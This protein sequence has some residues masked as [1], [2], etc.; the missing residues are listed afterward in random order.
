MKIVLL[1]VPASSR[2]DNS[3]RSCAFCACLFSTFDLSWLTTF[4]EQDLSRQVMKFLNR[5][6]TTLYNYCNRLYYLNYFSVFIHDVIHALSSCFI[7]IHG[8][9]VLH[10]LSTLQFSSNEL[11]KRVIRHSECEGR[12]LISRK[13]DRNFLNDNSIMNLY[14]QFFAVPHS[15]FRLLR[16]SK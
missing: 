2:S 7:I 9:I 14:S 3:A 5:F 1:V 13:N 6:I 4:T 15:P 11:K 12:Y 16:P 8:W 10:E